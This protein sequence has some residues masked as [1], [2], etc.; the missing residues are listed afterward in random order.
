[1]S[2]TEECDRR[3]RQKSVTEECEAT[4]NPLLTH[5]YSRASFEKCASLRSRSYKLMG[6][7]D[8][9]QTQNKSRPTKIVACLASGGGGA[10]ASSL[11]LLTNSSCQETTLVTIRSPHFSTAGG[12]HTLTIL[13]EKKHVLNGFLSSLER[14]LNK[15]KAT[16]STT[17][18]PLDSKLALLTQ[19]FKDYGVESG[20]DIISVKAELLKVS[21]RAKRA[22]SEAS[23]PCHRRVRRDCERSEPATPYTSQYTSCD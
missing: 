15:S 20:V 1:M 5:S 6:G 21:A 10:S 13:A 2:A 9:F 19:L 23:E 7:H 8:A 17:F 4:T 12:K 11:S 22:A 3:V 18:R 14:G 16:W